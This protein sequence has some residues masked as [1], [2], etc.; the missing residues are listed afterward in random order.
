MATITT[1]TYLD[2]GTARIAGETWTINGCKLKIRTDT[3]VHANAPASMTG[4]LG[5]CTTSTAL[6][7]GIEI[8]G[9][10][11]RW[12][13]YSGGSGNMPAIGTTVS[14]D[15]VSGYLLGCWADI[16]SAP[17]AVGA[18]I[19]ATGFMKFREVTGGT[20][21]AGALTGISASSSGPDVTGWIEIVSDAS[22]TF[23]LNEL[24]S[25]LVVNGDWF[26][27][28]TTNGSRGQSI[29]F[30]C[31]GG[32]TATWCNA[33][34]IETS[35]GSDVYEWFQVFS[36]S[37]GLANHTLSNFGIDARS[38]V[39]GSSGSTIYIGRDQTNVQSIGYLPPSGCRIRI[40]N[41]IHRTVATAARATNIFPS[42]S[43]CLINGG[44]F[45]L[46]SFMSD[47][48]FGTGS[49]TTVINNSSLCNSIDITDNINDI[50]I[51][52]TSIGL[53]TATFVVQ[54]TRC[55]NVT[56]SDS[57]M[58]TGTVTG[59]ICLTVTECDNVEIS[60]TRLFASK[61]RTSISGTP[62]AIAITYTSGANITNVK[63]L[64]LV[65]AYIAYSSDI[66][67]TNIDYCDRLDTTTGTT[68]GQSC[69]TVLSNT[70]VKVDGLT[71]GLNGIVADV[72]PYAALVTISAGCTNLT[73]RNFGTYS[74][75][76]TSTNSTYA[77][78]YLISG[79]VGGNNGIKCQKIYL[80][81]LRTNL[82]SLRINQLNVL[83]EDV[84]VG[85]MTGAPTV[86]GKNAIYRKLKIPT[87]VPTGVA[88]N[89]GIHWCDY[90]ENGDI[91]GKIMWLAGNPTPETLPYNTLYVTPTQG[92]G[93]VNSTFALSL[94]TQG[95]YLI[96]ECPYEFKGYTAFRNTAPTATGTT[97]GGFVYYYQ[98]DTG[99]GWNGTWKDLTAANLTAETI[100]PAGFKFKLKILQNSTGQEGSALKAVNISMVSTTQAQTENSYPLDTS[101]FTLTGL[102]PGSEV[103]IYQGINP[104]TSVEI[105]GIESTAGSDFTFSHSLSNDAGYIMILALGYQ[106]IYLPYTF[107]ATDESILIQPVIDRNYNNP[108]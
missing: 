100:S 101:N 52:N 84:Y 82:T 39:C 34:Q 57:V 6:G 75:P 49:M 15:G 51:T 19:P 25:G 70:N 41:V 54:L 48:R 86:Y 55:S 10:K 68:V 2:N 7:G 56:I 53:N 62:G 44:N 26:Y 37:L 81:R 59:Q 47:A 95:D 83:F 23:T 69:I 71:W 13:P 67:L 11:V 43:S 77:P 9:T 87:T 97:V 90:I 79:A 80:S 73:L 14:K 78:A 46:N 92:T 106:P 4:T 64:G 58:S 72:N 76:L 74:N 89:K 18:T 99:S 98:I 105:G 66:N 32:G 40:P 85:L 5:S 42:T 36:S 27:L 35:A 3:R 38:K 45:T 31:N 107:K 8:D 108:T 61:F 12:M 21:S 65:S 103:R 91:T 20:F 60:N 94:D 22:S 96:A 50:T 104:D 24:G 63:T 29:N 93:F 28:G 1:D 88:N 16:L 30:P 102:I 17:V 33:I